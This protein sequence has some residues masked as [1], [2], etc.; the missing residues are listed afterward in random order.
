MSNPSNS[1][2]EKIYSEHPL[3]LWALDDQA[4]YVSLITEEQRNIGSV[5]NGTGG[6][7]LPAFTDPTAPFQDSIVMGLISDVPATPGLYLY[8]YSPNLVNFQNLNTSLGTF[9][10]STYFYSDSVY[11]QEIQIGYEYTDPDTSEI[12]QKVKSFETSA[13]QRW[14]FISATFDTID[15]NAEFRIIFKLR[16]FPGAGSTEDYKVYFNGITAGQWSEEFNSQSLGLSVTSLPA[17]IALPSSDVIE[18]KEYQLAENNGYYFVS[19]NSI[20]GRNSGIPLV[21][22]ASSVTK[23]VPNLNMPSVIV[24]GKGFLNKAGQYNDYTVEFWMKI[25]PN[26]QDPVRIFGPIASEDGIYVESGFLTLVIGDTFKSHFVGEWYRPMLIQIRLIKDSVSLMMNGE[27]VLS[28]SIDTETL[29]LPEILNGEGKNQDW[30]GFYAT[31]ETTPFELDCIAIYSYNV[32]SIVA[33][34]RWVY[35]QAVVS[36]EKIDS[37]YNGISAYIDYPFANYVANYT[38]PDMAKWEQGAFDNLTTNLSFLSNP[39][40]PL[41]EIF[42]ES[43]TRQE[44]YQDCQALQIE[45]DKFITFRP[46]ETWN[47]INCYF[48]FPKFNIL[49]DEVHS[50]F[51]VFQ[52][53]ED[54]LSEQILMK[55]YN[56]LT[57]NFL[58]IKKVE[59]VIY[60]YLTY[61]STQLEI[62]STPFVIGE[63]FV[64]GV[65]ILKIVS[66]YGGDVASFFGN[67]N[68]LKLYIGGDESGT[69][70]FAGNIYK[71]GQGSSLNTSMTGNTHYYYT[72]VARPTAVEEFMAH[73][74]SYTL[75]PEVEYGQYYLDIGTYGR[76]EDYMPLSYFAKNVKNDVG[77]EYYALD[78]LQFNIGFPPPI[79]TITEN[80][81]EIFDTS[82]SEIRSFVTF[83]YIQNGSNLLDENFTT[84]MPAVGN[85]IIDLDQYPNWE[86]TKFEIVDNTL[87]YPSKN[88][89]FNNLAIVYSVEFRNRGTL[90]KQINLKN[91]QISSQA[92][93]NNSFNSVGTRFGVNLFPYK[94]SGIYY[95]YKTN[96]P[97]SIYK[98]S[99][100]YLYLTRNSGIELREVDGEIVERGIA[101]PINS[102]NANNYKVNAFQLWM[103]SDYSTFSDVPKEIFKIEDKE[104][105]II[106]YVVANSSQKN[107][108]KIYAR[109]K[110]TGQV[111]NGLAFYL[112]GKLVTEPVITIREW[113]VIGITFANSLNFN[114]Y[115]GKLTFNSS[116]IFNNIG[117]YQASSL[118]DIQSKITRP[119][120]NVKT[121][122]TSELDWQYWENSYNWENVLI[123]SSK[124]AYAIN[125]SDIY[126]TYI[127]SN[128]IIIDDSEGAIIDSETIKIYS[129]SSWSSLVQTPL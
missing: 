41:P 59:D 14:S 84:V 75:F 13:Y 39:Q 118:Q 45:T 7:S 69:K 100:P 106:F 50:F 47:D 104:D 115:I 18:A 37:S 33:K 109:K 25:N 9:A 90:T 22:G 21:Y 125:P 112:N 54:D 58:E 5:W 71:F 30:L 82:Q 10:L 94:K 8:T 126:N 120:F 73:L 80:N 102:Q 127:G 65:D 87:L 67:R 116:F 16:F 121:T 74:A 113:N 6:G 3:A 96:N 36:P 23:L 72:G 85:R 4:D 99:T 68:G 66:E 129:N 63:K 38:Y 79:N 56:T 103:M 29:N 34:R 53:N 128:K 93:N 111:Y 88:I 31:P 28:F 60:Y 76:W 62:Y 97:F 122:G 108:A 110:S 91:L 98:G 119:W 44:L 123:V 46:N 43:K 105:T 17:G 61:N 26:T 81:L 27:E 92:L 42:I 89:D 2:A 24:P 20:L 35:G 52:I 83:Q 57:G 101:I 48:N 12:I 78:F 11:L 1:Y 77:N 86:T 95:D 19:N 64:I 114:S 40:Y 51:G 15:V 124:E 32:P 70:T 49:N 55:L 107:R 117:T